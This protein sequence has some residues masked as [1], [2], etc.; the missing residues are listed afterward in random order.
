ML[1]NY[2]KITLRN[3]AKQKSYS[4]IN[5]AGL[6]L[7][8]ALFIL[9]ARFIQFEFSFDQFHKNYDQIHR[10]EYNLDG[11][12]RL[13]AFSHPPLGTLLSR[14]FPEIE[15]FTRFLNMD[16]GVLLSTNNDQKYTEDD[17]W[18]AEHTFFEVFSYQLLQG[19]PK[20]ALV[21]SNCIVLSQK[22]A[23]KY[24]PDEEPLGKVLRYNNT[25]D[26]KVTG[27]LENCPANS[28]IQYSFLIS[29]PTYKTIAG[30][31]YFDSWNNIANYTYV[32]LA[33]D[34]NL[35]ALNARL[36]TVLKKY[37]RDD[38]EVPLYLKP[39]AQFHFHSNV[40]GEI[41]QR[42]DMNKIIIFSAIGLFILLIACINFM[43]LATARAAKRTKEVGLRKVIG[44]NKF[45]LVQRF[46]F[47]SLLFA[48]VA[49]MLAG[50]LAEI[51]LPLFNKIIG[52]TLTL[53]LG[54]DWQFI[55]GLFF[56]TIIVGII[57]GSY[58]SFFLSSF[59]PAFILR[60][61][62]ATPGV[63]SAIRKF[64]VVFQ[65]VISIVLIIGTL[66]IYRQM[67]YMRHTDLGFNDEQIIINQFP[68]MDKETVSK[69]ET[70]KNELRSNPD[71]IDATISRDVPSF[72]SSSIVIL[73]WE[74]SHEGD[75]AY[76]NVNQIDEN[77]LATYNI[78]L[79]D[80]R[81]FS[82]NE[83]RDT[84]NYCIINEAAVKRFGWEQAIG[85]RLGGNMNVIGV[86][87]D[88]HYASL[89]FQIEPL[90]LFPHREPNPASRARNYLSLKIAPHHL[91]ETLAFFKNK[92]EAFFPND[93]FS[94]HFFDEDFDFMYRHEARFAKTISYFSVIAIFIACL[95][96][97]GLAS[98]TAEQRTKEIGIRKIC[99]AA[100]SG[101]VA[102]LSR[103]FIKWILMA[104]VIAWP[105]AYLIMKK[106]L[107]N[108]AYHIDIGW[109]IFLCAGVLALIIAL[110]TVSYQ[111]IRAATENPVKALRCE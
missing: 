108:F 60:N 15:Q 28:H 105:I 6:A 52:R 67:H 92:Y 88:F 107:Q 80:G 86:I 3:I 7:G 10:V 94:Y 82:G 59:Q 53:G 5:I 23:E 99:G 65:F 61:P 79:V 21:E 38:L 87:K 45:S 57:A 98:F 29:Y 32:L 111:S 30:S 110:L 50:F 74:G 36:S 19:D 44:A 68:R 35:E 73:D 4:F 31:D 100:V 76:V 78:K 70:L 56:I 25:I 84:V 51:F 102:M 93:V 49:L 48:L 33:K 91:D 109:W 20:T 101:I 103:D 81:N 27:V 85:K 40:V 1:R 41:G 37:W 66:V 14:D 22:L 46:L 69:Y 47:E 42:G 95:G 43:N 62:S 89:R 12:G 77:F 54:D 96:L 17:G 9:I 75:R 71:I 90:V 55:A 16:N 58:P 26:C 24:F 64:L 83:S 18:W 72:N 63:S 97:F 2:L 34:T 106:W 11:K 8:L 13:I 39:L 104:N